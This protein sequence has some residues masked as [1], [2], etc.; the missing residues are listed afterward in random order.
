MLLPPSVSGVAFPA[1]DIQ[2][3]E[4]LS[5]HLL[6]QR[7]EGCHTDPRSFLAFHEASE[8]SGGTLG[9]QEEPISCL[10]WSSWAVLRNPRD[11][12][13]YTRVAAQTL[14]FSARTHHA[15]LIR[16]GSAWGHNDVGG[17]TWCRGSNS[18]HAGHVYGRV[19]VPT[20]HP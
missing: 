9:N 20:P 7:E 3:Q 12:P 8:I 10:F 5:L 14:L 4:N 1:Q 16:P 15:V 19:S 17:T 6:G 18:E 13:S 11:F 2:S